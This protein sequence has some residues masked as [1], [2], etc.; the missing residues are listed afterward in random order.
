MKKNVFLVAGAARDFKI[1][2]WIL[3]DIVFFV[4]H[5]SCAKS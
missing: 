4:S 5:K 2:I 1:A 3:S